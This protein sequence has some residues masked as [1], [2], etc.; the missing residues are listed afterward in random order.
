MV[1]SFAGDKIASLVRFAGARLVADCGLPQTVE[2]SR[3]SPSP[4]AHGPG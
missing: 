3:V 4:G 2:R 1:F